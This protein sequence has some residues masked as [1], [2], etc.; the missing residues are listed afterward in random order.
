MS[1]RVE[2]IRV[3]KDV[4]Q[5]AAELEVFA[6][7]KSNFLMHS[8]IPV[9]KPRT[10]ADGSLRSVVEVAERRVLEIVR[11]KP[12]TAVGLGI[13]LLER[14]HQRWC[15]GTQEENTCDQFVVIFGVQANRESALELRNARNRPVINQLAHEPFVLGD[16]QLPIV[17][18]DET[19][20]R[21]EDRRR[22][23]SCEI[24]R[25]ECFLER[26]AVID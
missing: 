15:F 21:V 14:S 3:I 25:I 19:L 22:P 8:E 5:F 11:I 1:I 17:A 9:L 24:K 4:E 20:F 2:K 26:R 12:E 6:L 10:A 23:A 7:A 13:Q 16:R 18:D